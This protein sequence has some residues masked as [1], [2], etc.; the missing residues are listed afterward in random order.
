MPNKKDRKGKKNLRKNVDIT[1]VEQ[2]EEHQREEALAGGPL[3]KRQ[4][5][6]LFVI[7]KKKGLFGTRMHVVALHLTAFLSHSYQ[8]KLRR[9]EKQR[10][11][12]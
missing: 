10:T 6:D 4:N 7:D 12:N 2:H 3:E 1:D 11:E 9:M 8:A 5:E